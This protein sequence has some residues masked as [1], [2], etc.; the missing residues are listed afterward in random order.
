MNPAK[1]VSDRCIDELTPSPR[2]GLLSLAV[3]V[4]LSVAWF[5]LRS[6]D[7]RDAPSSETDGREFLPVLDVPGVYHAAPIA[8][9]QDVSA[10]ANAA[11]APLKIEIATNGWCWISAESDDARVLYG[12]IEPGKRVVL[13]AQR[14]ISLRLGDGGAVSVSINDAP[15]RTPG[16]PGEVV[17]F[18]LTP[19]SVNDLRDS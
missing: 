7:V 9:R 13:E 18:E 15:P 17:A 2:K 14:R 19:D 8:A 4:T 12:L 1:T 10:D 5:M 6:D 16:R 11:S 3:L